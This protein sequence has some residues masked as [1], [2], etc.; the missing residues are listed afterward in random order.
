VGAS[1]SGPVTRSSSQG[2]LPSSRPSRHL[3]L[4]VALSPTLPRS[5]RRC[6]GLHPTRHRR[7]RRPALSPRRRRLHSR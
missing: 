5:R 2:V 7:R 4:P 6:A 1:G 3:R